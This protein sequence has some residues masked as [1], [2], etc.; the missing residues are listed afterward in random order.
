MKPSNLASELHRVFSTSR[1]GEGSAPLHQRDDALQ[2]VWEAVAEKARE[3]L[4]GNHAA[5]AKPAPKRTPDFL[6]IETQNSKGEDITI[7]VTSRAVTLLAYSTSCPSGY[8]LSGFT[9]TKKKG[10]YCGGVSEFE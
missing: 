10:Q 4:V 2:S 1:F 8:R 5:Q 9:F 3:L 7:H 6:D